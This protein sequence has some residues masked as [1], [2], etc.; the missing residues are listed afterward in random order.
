M[1]SVE[2]EIVEIKLF[3]SRAKVNKKLLEAITDAGATFNDAIALLYA[4]HKC[5]L[6]KVNSD[7]KF[8]NNKGEVIDVEKEAVFEARVFNAKAELRWLNKENGAGEAVVLCEDKAQKFFS[9]EPQADDKIYARIDPPQ[10][11]LMWGESIGASSNGWTKF[12][13]A[14]IRPFYVPIGDINN[15]QKRRAHFKAVEYL[16]EY[17]DGN[18]AVAEE[19]LTGIQAVAVKQEAKENNG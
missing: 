16:G 6:A 10:T 9:V 4:P 8:E 2:S 12:A 17:S 1:A 7:G 15:K 5:F 18:V 13:E 19:R 14:R 11:Y 3:I